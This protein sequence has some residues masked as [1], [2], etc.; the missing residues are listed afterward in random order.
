MSGNIKE[1]QFAALLYPIMKKRNMSIAA[2]AAAVGVKRHTCYSW[3]HEYRRP[4]LESLRGISRVLSIP[5]ADLIA[6]TYEDV[7]GAILESHLEAY[8]HLSKSKQHLLNIIVNAWLE[9]EKQSSRPP[10]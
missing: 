3:F 1:G 5:I 4:S 10:Q 8:L 2:L 6:A 7:D 9:D